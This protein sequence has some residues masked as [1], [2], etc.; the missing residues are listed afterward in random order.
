M[1]DQGAR[2][3]APAER[4]RDLGMLS[5]AAVAVALL[6]PPRADL[7]TRRKAADLEDFW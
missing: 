4:V 5:L 7:L 6:T 2:K 1:R 3:I